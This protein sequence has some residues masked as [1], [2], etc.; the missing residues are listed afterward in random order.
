MSSKRV[1][2][3][4]AM[5]Q[6][7]AKRSRSN[8]KV[9]LGTD[10]AGLETPRMALENIGFK[11]Q[12]LFT[13]DSDPNCRKMM[14]ALYG[15]AERVFHDVQRKQSDQAPHVDLYV[16]GVCCQPWSTAGKHGGLLGQIDST[17]HILTCQ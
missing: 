17:L 11:V 14:A 3:D 13:C 4:V 7:N 15:D 5:A 12:Q 6:P 9:T 2:K 1:S 16:A 10:F 8:L